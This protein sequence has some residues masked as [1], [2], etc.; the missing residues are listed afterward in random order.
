M[1]DRRQF[2]AAQCEA[3]VT[4]H[5]SRPARSQGTGHVGSAY[6]KGPGAERQSLYQGKFLSRPADGQAT[7][8][9]GSARL[10]QRANRICPFE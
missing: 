10:I 1:I 4:K 3:G 9:P 2:A 6:Q 8:D 5:R 7:L